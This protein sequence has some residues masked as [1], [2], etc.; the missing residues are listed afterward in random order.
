[1]R[2]GVLCEFSGVVR[3]AFRRRGNDAVSCN[4]LEDETE[5]GPHIQGD[6]LKQDWS[7]FDLLIC[8]PPCTH[9]AIS[10]ARWFAQRQDQ[11]RQALDFVRALL[12]LPVFCLALENPIGILSTRV[13]PPDQ[14]IQPYNFGHG[15][16]KSTCLWLRG[17]PLLRPTMVVRYHK[18]SW[19]NSDR[20]HADRGKSRSRTFYGIAEAMAD[21]WSNCYGPPTRTAV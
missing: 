16:S 14:I 19:R 10:G 3:D 5:N 2:V 11:Q 18:D 12:A 4:L 13:R 1:M 9:L 20:Q 6:V 15:V 21:Q 8:H 17:L 7:G